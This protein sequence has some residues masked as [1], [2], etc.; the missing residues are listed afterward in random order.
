MSLAQAGKLA[1][2]PLRER[3]LRDAQAA[4]DELRAGKVA[5]RVVLTS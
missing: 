2:I 1:P 3:P 5:G 4:L